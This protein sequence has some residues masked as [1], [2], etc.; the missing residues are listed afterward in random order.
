[1]RGSHVCPILNEL[2]RSQ[3]WYI[4]TLNIGIK[5]H[6]QQSASI[7]ITEL[8]IITISLTAVNRIIC[9]APKASASICM[10]GKIIL[11]FVEVLL[12]LSMVVCIVCR[13]SQ[14]ICSNS[15]SVI[16]V[17]ARSP[18]MHVRSLYCINRP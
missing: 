2:L 1:M 9:R 7:L 13:S 17:L 5:N 16:T 6:F 18:Y 11:V 12:L 3:F 15:G 10:C 8:V 4:D 14:S